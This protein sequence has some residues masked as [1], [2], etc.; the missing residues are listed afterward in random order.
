VTGERETAGN[1]L[2]PWAVM[3]QTFGVR[4]AALAEVGDTS[5]GPVIAWPEYITSADF[6]GRGCFLES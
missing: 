4:Q 3:D 2:S 6:Q 5:V 1:R